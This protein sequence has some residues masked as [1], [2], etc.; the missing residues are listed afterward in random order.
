[1]DPVMKTY[2]GK[3]VNPLNIRVEDIDI[4]DIAHHLATINRFTVALK[5]P[6]SVAQHSIYV[7]RLLDGSGVEPEALFH[8]APEA[9]LNDINKWLKRTDVMKG[10]R[11]AE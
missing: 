8:D 11:E 1:M 10:Y 7:A 3:K 5:R 2:T 4:R 6:V 9:Y